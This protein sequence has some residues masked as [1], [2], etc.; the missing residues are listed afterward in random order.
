MNARSKVAAA[1]TPPARAE[2]LL[3]CTCNCFSSVGMLLYN[4][5]AIEAFPLE[6]SLVWMQLA[7]ATLVILCFAWPSIHIG[8][9]RDL[10]RWSAVVPFYCGMLM[11][12][13]LALKSAPMSLII[14]MRNASPLAAL[15][16]ERFYP[17]PLR[18]SAPM[19]FSIMIMVAGAGMYVSQ[20]PHE[21]LEGVGWVLLNSAVAVGDR[22]LQRLLLSK[23]QQPVDISRPGVILINN[24]CGLLPV[25]LLVLMHGEAAQLSQAYASLSSWGVLY[26]FLSC[27]IGVS[28][29]YTGVWAQSLISATSFLV[30][31]NANKFVIVGIEAFGL[32][33]KALSPLQVAGASI[34]ILGGIL[35]SMEREALEKEEPGEKGPLLPSGKP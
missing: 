12:S 1:R 16:I 29:S 17:A 34:T 18:I 14:V 28:L 5:L 31:V 6:C 3:A 11:T 25:G 24:L 21:H 27:L 22:L 8:S 2:T 9:F 7:F 26:I 20:L 33:A 23:D 10:C 4:K 30:M 19:L 32:H 13:I 15:A 35:Y